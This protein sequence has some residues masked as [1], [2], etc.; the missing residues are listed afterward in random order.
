MI[1]FTSVAVRVFGF[2]IHYYGIIIMLGVLCSVYLATR[3]ATRRGMDAEYLL[4]S[5]VWVLIGGIIGAV[6]VVGLVIFYFF[7]KKASS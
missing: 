2:D 5:V 7:R 3:E 1:E 6:I 4:D